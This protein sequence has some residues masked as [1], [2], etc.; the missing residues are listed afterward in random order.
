MPFSRLL[1]RLGLLSA[2]VV[3]SMVPD[4]GYLMPIRP[5]RF[6]THSVIALATFCLP[7]GLLSY[8]IFQRVMKTPLL[9]VLPDQAYMRWRPY[10]APA[11]IGSPRQWL[12]AAC[13]VLAGAVVHLAWD[14][15]THEE[16][17]GVRMLPGLADPVLEVNGHLLTG[18]RLLQ[19]LSSLLG[20][21]LVLAA[22][23]YALRGSGRLV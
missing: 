12:L 10:S 19:D 21:L 20:L 3:G 7:V 13:G 1:A 6:E 14:A 16:A 17:R 2:V 9:S 22:I 8:W 23:V 4:F 5:P 11:A 18:A 15:F